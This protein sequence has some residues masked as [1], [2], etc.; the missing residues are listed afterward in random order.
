MYTAQESNSHY[1]P[2][3]YTPPYEHELRYHSLYRQCGKLY[4]YKRAQG[5]T[6]A[7]FEYFGHAVYESARQSAVDL[8]ELRCEAPWKTNDIKESLKDSALMTSSGC[9]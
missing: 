3:H 6:Q 8:Q 1:A 4:L 7:E 9:T 5:K 2:Q